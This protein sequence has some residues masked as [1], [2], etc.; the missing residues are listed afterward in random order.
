[1]KF[2]AVGPAGSQTLGTGLRHPS[3]NCC[4]NWLCHGSW[5]TVSWWTGFCWCSKGSKFVTYNWNYIWPPMLLTPAQIKP[6]L[7][8]QRRNSFFFFFFF[9]LGGH[10]S[11]FYLCLDAV[12]LPQSCKDP[13]LSRALTASVDS[14]MEIDKECPFSGITSSASLQNGARK[15]D[16]QSVDGV[17]HASWPVSD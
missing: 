6:K 8:E 15:S 17:C 13:K 4:H 2:M 5:K 10:A 12:L 14:Y 1:M 16:A 11:H 7:F 9:T 3:S